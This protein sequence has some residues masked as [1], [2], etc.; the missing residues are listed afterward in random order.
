MSSEI[1]NFRGSMDHT[2]KRIIILCDTV[3][4]IHVEYC[5]TKVTLHDLAT[6]FFAW[7]EDHV[8][9]SRSIFTLLH[10]QR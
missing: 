8:S 1:E 2:E 5:V 9:F 3:T 6:D 10:D 4:L 7:N